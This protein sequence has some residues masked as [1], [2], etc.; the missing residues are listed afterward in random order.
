MLGLFHSQPR[1]HVALVFKLC[2]ARSFI[3]ETCL[4]KES[5]EYGNYG[6][7]SAGI[8]GK[9]EP[10]KGIGKSILLKSNELRYDESVNALA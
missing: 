10:S 2:I 1:C 8:L 6:R 7:N 3:P 4:G 9:G 5:W